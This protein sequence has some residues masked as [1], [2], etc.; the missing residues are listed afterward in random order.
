MRYCLNVYY[1][2]PDL[3]FLKKVIRIRMSTRLFQSQK[4]YSDRLFLITQ[5]PTKQDIL[6]SL[7]WQ[8][9]NAGL[10]EGWK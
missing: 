2:N 7:K 10:L 6:N 4:A 3:T 5:L 9:K 1:I 8:G